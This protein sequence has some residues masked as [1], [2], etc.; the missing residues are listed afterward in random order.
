[1]RE[2]GEEGEGVGERAREGGKAVAFIGQLFRFASRCRLLADI[3]DENSALATGPLIAS[4][5]SAN[6]GK[7]RNLERCLAK[8]EQKLGG[9]VEVKD[10]QNIVVD[11]EAISLSYTD[12]TVPCLTATRCATGTAHWLLGYGRSLSTTE[13]MRLQG[14]PPTLLPSTQVPR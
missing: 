1:M 5:P 2:G 3:L 9:P 12:G 10:V 11:Y 4:F 14:V 7:R 6:T 13:L 8:L